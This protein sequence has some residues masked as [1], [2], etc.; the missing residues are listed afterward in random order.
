MYFPKKLTPNEDGIIAIGGSMAPD[1]LIEAYSRGIFPWPHDDYPLLWFYPLE[2]GILFFN[3]F[4]I[5]KSMK[6][7]LKKCPWTITWDKDF[8]AVI[9]NCAKI[10][11]PNQ[12]G[13]WINDEVLQSYIEFHKKGYAHSIE[14]WEGDSLVGGV[15]GV[16]VNN[17]FSAESMFYLK[18]NASKVALYYLIQKLKSLNLEWIDVQMVTEITEQF[19]AEYIS[20]LEYS[21]LL[22]R[23]QVVT[24]V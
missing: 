20:H 19:G 14:V 2:R 7:F 18:S 24:K 23:S 8:S 22:K 11:R 1:V 13:T 6:K 12:K 3:K 10:P 5:S 9:K 16:F 17:I 4:H 21:K 15:Y